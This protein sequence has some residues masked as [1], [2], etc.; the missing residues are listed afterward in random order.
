MR[1]RIH[2]IVQIADPGDKL[3]SYYDKFMLVSIIVSLFP[4][5]FKHASSLFRWIELITVSVFIVDYLFRWITADYKLNEKSISVFIKYPFTFFA[6]IDLLSILPSLRVLNEGF[7]LFRIL[8]LNRAFRTLRLLRYSKSFNLIL[9]V[10]DKERKPL[11]A[12]VYLAGGYVLLTALII[13]Q[14]EPE[15]FNS[16]FDAFYWAVVTLTTVGYG[17]IYPVSY[18]GRIIGMF[19]S[20]MGIAIVALPTGIITAGYMNELNKNN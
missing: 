14:V 6:I 1:E 5:F 7:K 19:S 11:M 20:F 2:K 4:L 18:F 17:D 3:S 9:S 15:S 16:F 12:V 8:R 10:V 13:F